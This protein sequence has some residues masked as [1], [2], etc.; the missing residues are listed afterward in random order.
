GACLIV[1]PESS[2]PVLAPL[3]A[4]VAAAFVPSDP[5]EGKELEERDAD[6]EKAGIEA[7][8]NVPFSH[9]AALIVYTSGTTGRPKGV[10]HSHIGLASQ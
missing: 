10:V 1:G 6:E 5:L 9:A 3:A 7:L 4:E 8:K 2:R